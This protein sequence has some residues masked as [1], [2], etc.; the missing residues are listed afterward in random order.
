MDISQEKPYAALVPDNPENS[1][2]PGHSMDIGSRWD[3]EENDFPEDND[4]IAPNSPAEY[5]PIQ[6]SSGFA[7]DDVRVQ[8]NLYGTHFSADFGSF[9]RFKYSPCGSS[10]VSDDSTT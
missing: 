5:D 1:I 7:L 6:P 4:P 10:L 9:K 8:Y 3:A 2:D